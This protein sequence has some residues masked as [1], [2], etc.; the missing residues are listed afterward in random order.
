M[1]AIAFPAIGKKYY[2]RKLFSSRELPVT[3]VPA[4]D[5]AK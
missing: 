2:R 1:A 4:R 5:G 3:K